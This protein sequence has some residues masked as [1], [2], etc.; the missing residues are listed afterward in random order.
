MSNNIHELRTGDLE[1]KMGNRFSCDECGWMEFW[2]MDNLDIVCSN[3]KILI[4]NIEVEIIK[5][6]LPKEVNDE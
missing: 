3:C 5:Q 2:I 4:K 1:R 6:V